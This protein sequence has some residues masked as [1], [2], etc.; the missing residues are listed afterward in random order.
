VSRL[1]VIFSMLGRRRGSV[2]AGGELSKSIGGGRD[3]VLTFAFVDY[4]CC[5]VEELRTS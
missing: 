4:S 3:F 5:V 1:V 2:G